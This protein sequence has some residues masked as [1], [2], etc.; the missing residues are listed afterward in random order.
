MVSDDAAA[1]P[2]APTPQRAPQQLWPRYNTEDDLPAIEAVPLSDRGL[3]AT[4]YAALVRAAEL[5]PHRPAA[6]VLSD[7]ERWRNP[8]TLTFGQLL[9]D[10][11]RY[12][13]LLHTLGVGRHTAVALMSPNTAQF[14]SALLAAQR[15][16]IAAPLNPGLSADHIGELL[17]R[18]GARVLIAAG[19]D[20]APEIWQRAQT[21]AAEQQLDAVLALRPADAGASA[22]ELTPVEGVRVGYLDDADPVE[23]TAEPPAPGASDLAAFFHTGG[24]TGTPKLA[25]HTHSMEVANA[26]M[27]A[28]NSVLEDRS[29]LFAALPL[30]HVN[31]LIVTVLAPML[32]GQQV[33][34]AG[35]LGYREPALMRNFWRI[36][37]HYRI[38]AMSGVPTIY[39]VLA[40]LTVDADISSLRVPIVG[41]A[42]LPAAIRAA[43]AER[44]GVLLN[45]GYGL[46]EATCASARTFPD[47]PRPGSVGQRLPYQE[48]KTVAVGDDGSW[49]DLPAGEL[50][51]LAIRGPNVFPG[52]V[53]R[54]EPDAAPEL[55]GMGKLT[56]GWLDTGDL[57]R[58]DSDGYLY[59]LGRAKDLIIRGG[60]NLDPA[61]IEDALLEHPEVTDAS[62]VGRPDAHSGEV[63]IAY[64]TLRAG[65]SRTG[66]SIRDW[67]SKR[68]TERAAVP[69][70]VVIRDALPVT[71]VGKPYKVA[72]RADAVVREIRDALARAGVTLAENAVVCDPATGALEVVVHAP[73][74]SDLRAVIATAVDRYAV[75][76]RFGQTEQD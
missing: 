70:E 3:P 68:I 36:V 38:A 49:H 12:A 40:Q 74:D 8:H 52:Y 34:W 67:V 61:V 30:F 4:S 21:I 43:F 7:G 13:N 55:D 45:E 60:H 53:V 63:P 2:D 6:T 57:A 35:P 58:V 69:K 22:A 44:T 65:S 47:S 27:V 32:R 9:T 71:A 76:W 73:A 20:L 25:A 46:T 29:V 5:W 14:I 75:R 28:A 10:V 33:I 11:R 24:T 31:A 39:G 23:P 56:D 72:L 59:L 66:D 26:W 41:A 48:F 19:P 15:A 54:N 17:R 37:E 42:P 1:T 18:G 51:T 64:V 62:A 16:G 50:G